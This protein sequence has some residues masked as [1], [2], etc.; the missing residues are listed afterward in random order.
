MGRVAS[1]L[2]RVAA[3][4]LRGLL[5]GWRLL[6]VWVAVVSGR[7]LTHAH[8]CTASREVVAHHA[9]HG[10]SVGHGHRLHHCGVCEERKRL[11]Y[12]LGQTRRKKKS[13][14][15]LSSVSQD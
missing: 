1:L 5:L 8:C 2:V 10:A 6:H 15:S 11:S 13:I 4:L 9:A 14:V 12:R 3:L 7:Y